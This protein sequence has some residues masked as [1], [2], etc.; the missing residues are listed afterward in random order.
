MLKAS[1][2]SPA[3][4]MPS[5]SSLSLMSSSIAVRIESASSSR[6]AFGPPAGEIRSCISDTA[7]ATRPQVSLSAFWSSASFRDESSWILIVSPESVTTLKDIRCPSSSDSESSFS[8]RAPVMALSRG[9]GTP[10]SLPL[11]PAGGSGTIMIWSRVICTSVA[12]TR[13]VCAASPPLGSAPS[14]D[15]RAVMSEGRC[16]RVSCASAPL[17]PSASPAAPLPAPPPGTGASRRT[18]ACCSQPF[19][20]SLSR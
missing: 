14:K 6:D 3:S 16:L 12:G 9:S 18:A 13:T 8:T 19:S 7:S 10:A 1:G 2:E 4:P 17:N 15:V 11:P 20:L 5:S